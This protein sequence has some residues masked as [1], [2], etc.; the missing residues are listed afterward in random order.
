MSVGG[1]RH[2]IWQLKQ[3]VQR[4][5]FWHV[6]GT[7]GDEPPV[8]CRSRH[9]VGPEQC[10][11]GVKNRDVFWW[12]CQEWI[13]FLVLG[14]S[15][16]FIIYP[17]GPIVAGFLCLTAYPNVILV[18]VPSISTISA[19]GYWPTHV[20]T[21]QQQTIIYTDTYTLHTPVQRE[22]VAND[23]CKCCYCSCTCF[24]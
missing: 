10:G 19:S 17:F 22:T 7:P 13:H 16:I 6:V 23:W 8:I 4:V 14:S 15:R 24:A 18:K 9:L 12:T 1:L 11:R 2:I 3:A 21:L 5:R 20:D